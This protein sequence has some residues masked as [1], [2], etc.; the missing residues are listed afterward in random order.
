[1]YVLQKQSISL[2]SMKEQT[3]E[4]KK[5]PERKKEGH[6]Q[7]DLTMILAR[8]S[9]DIANSQDHGQDTPMWDLSVQFYIGGLHT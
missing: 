9:Q 5:H 4:S 6:G 8:S 3:N 2:W 7:N 1:M